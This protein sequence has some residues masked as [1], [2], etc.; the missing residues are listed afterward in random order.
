MAAWLRCCK[1]PPSSCNHPASTAQTGGLSVGRDSGSTAALHRHTLQGP[2][3]QTP[4]YDRSRWHPERRGPCQDHRATARPGAGHPWLGVPAELCV[5]FWGLRTRHRAAQGATGAPCLPVTRASLGV[6]P[7]PTYQSDR[8]LSPCL[9][10]SN[11]PP[12]VA[13]DTWRGSQLGSLE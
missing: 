3:M 4:F 7:L 8:K 9:L 1:K 2:G 13:S 12:V 6:H 5:G 10:A 11:V